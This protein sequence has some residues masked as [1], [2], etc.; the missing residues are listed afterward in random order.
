MDRRSIQQRGDHLKVPETRVYLA[1][2][3]KSEHIAEITRAKIWRVENTARDTK[4]VRYV[5][6]CRTFISFEYYSE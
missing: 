2:F 3:Q 4:E 1:Y 6:V 5:R